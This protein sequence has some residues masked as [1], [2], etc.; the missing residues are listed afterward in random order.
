M[1]EVFSED[2]LVGSI[3]QEENEHRFHYDRLWIESQDSFPVSTSF[4]VS[5]EPVSA[6]LLIPWLANLLPEGD[7]LNQ[8]ARTL[9]VS[10]GDVLGVL[11]RIGR[12]T[13]GAL[14][15]TSRGNGER[16]WEIIP[17]EEDLERIIEELH[18]KPF[19]AGEQG[20]S[21]SLAG[22]Q[23]KMA[24][25]R[26]NDGRLYIPINGSPSTHILKPDIERLPGSVSS[27]AL[28]LALAKRCGLPAAD[29][30]TGRAGTRN[31][32]LV[33]RYDR[34]VTDNH[35]FRVHQEDLCQAL[36]VFPS[37]KYE[38]NDTGTP[39]PSLQDMADCL[40]RVAEPKALLTFL[41]MVIFN[42][43]VCNPDAHAKN[44]SVLIYP[45]NVKL[46]PMYDVMCA[47]PWDGINLHLANKIAGKND[48]KYI[49][50]RHWQRE[51]RK[52]GLNPTIAL[53]RV[54]R[55]ANSVLAEL[56]KALAYVEAMP[57]GEDPML[58][59]FGKAIA[60]RC[61]SVLNGLKETE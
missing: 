26:D 41:D 5:A 29:V 33:K 59:H 37:Q 30:D 54:S 15:F 55:L 40:R 20:I 12:E 35:I 7:P 32:L 4:P 27:E 57:T 28:C 39:G 53:H 17:T 23:T 8:L 45:G 38:T 10:T 31:Y 49:K 47:E 11:K 43:L 50:G 60:T 61:T 51:T 18:E 3:L 44:Y 2:R 25:G 34:I 58:K 56:E 22:A 21:L 6:D 1:M 16:N 36:G 9:R 13:S 14:S 19:L 24:V 48:G 52:W 42:V 46:A